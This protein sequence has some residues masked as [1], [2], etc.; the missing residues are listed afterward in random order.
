MTDRDP[1]SSVLAQWQPQPDSAPTFAAEVQARLR[2]PP[3][4]EA[5]P[6]ARILQFPATLPLAAGFAIM[7]GVFSA[8]SMNRSEAQSQMADSYARSIDPVWMTASTHH[9]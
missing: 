6:L 9:P 3:A 7:I 5:P 4:S 8:I 2:E 1:L